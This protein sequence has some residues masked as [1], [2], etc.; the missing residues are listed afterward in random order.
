MEDKRKH[1][2]VCANLVVILKVKN[3]RLARGSRTKDI[4]ETGICIPLNNYFPVGSLL[5][6]EMRSI[7]LKGPIRSLARV[8]RIA[9]L[10]D[11]Y[12]PFEMG[13]EFIDFPVANRRIFSEYIRLSLPTLHA[14]HALHGC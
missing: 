3:S 2:R 12:T 5:E 9:K 13:V 11:G 4:S 1:V 14:L 6:L 10:D 7:D 8:V